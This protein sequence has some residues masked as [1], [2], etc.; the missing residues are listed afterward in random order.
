MFRVLPC[1]FI[2]SV[3]CCCS[4][5]QIVVVV[6]VYFSHHRDD[7]KAMSIRI[8]TFLK[9]GFVHPDTFRQGVSKTRVEF[10]AGIGIYLFSKECRFKV[11][12]RVDTNPC[13]EYSIRKNST[14]F[15]DI[16]LL[17]EIF[18]WESQKVVFYLLSN[19]IYQL[20]L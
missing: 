14:T 18:R 3:S 16:P 2:L 6:V 12:V 19:R 5:Y 11:R 9:R 13:L 7:S 17:P 10:G 4:V 20:I 1:P 8:R 15:S